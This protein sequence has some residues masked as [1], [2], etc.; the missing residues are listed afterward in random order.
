[1]GDGPLPLSPPAN[2]WMRGPC[3][4][5]CRAEKA[6]VMWIGPARVDGLIAPMY[7][8][9]QCIRRLA[10]LAWRETAR[11]DS[12][13]G[14]PAPTGETALARFPYRLRRNRPRQR[15]RHRAGRPS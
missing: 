2:V 6:L 4:L 10:A 14:D 12:P 7:A 15:G 8:C 9:A 1:M 5:Y 3:W 11:A 13:T